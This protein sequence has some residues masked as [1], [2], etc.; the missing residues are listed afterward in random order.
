KEGAAHI[1]ANELGIKV[2]EQVSG[3]LQIKNILPGMRSVETVGKVTQKFDIHEFQKEDRKG[4]L[5]SM[6]IGDETGTIRIVLWQEQADKLA[7]IKEGD[8][9]KLVDGYSKD[10]QGRKEVHIGD[11]GNIIINPPDETV[12]DVKES[13]AVRKKIKDLRENDADAEIFGT[14]VQLFDIRFFEVCPECG[15]R[16]KMADD[17][18]VCETHN[19]VSPNY[20]YVL[21]VHLDDGSE[22]IRVVCFRNQV[23]T[24]LNKTQEDILTYREAPEKFEEVKTE[25]LGNQVKFV[26][27]VVNNTMFNRLEFISNQVFP[28][29]S[30]E[31]EIERLSEEKSAEEAKAEEPKEEMEIK[32][33]EIVEDVTKS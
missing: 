15:K 3:K 18:F 16:A 21:N 29:P 30:P 9:V 26:G 20:S 11:R 24:L 23:E 22:N 6:I 12:G 5:G 28:N 13:N 2:I 17:S 8:I 14:I 7:S 27:R 10:N 4:K 33:E 32:Q 31:E 1:V 19:K 25:L